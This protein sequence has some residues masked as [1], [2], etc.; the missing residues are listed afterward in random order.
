RGDGQRPRELLL[1]G[2]AQLLHHGE[3]RRAHVGEQTRLKLFDGGRVVEVVRAPAE[4]ASERG[5]RLVLREERGALLR[6]AVVELERLEPVF[7][8]REFLALRGR[9]LAQLLARLLVLPVY[10]LE[11]FARVLQ[12]AFELL[13]LRVEFVRVRVQARVVGE[14]WDALSARRVVVRQLARR[15]E[16][17]AVEHV[18]APEPRRFHEAALFDPGGEFREV[19]RRLQSGLARGG[20][21]YG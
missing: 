11:S 10:G 20:L 19:V 21:L 2:R 14:E 8:A 18:A 6:R 16:P 15:R 5:Q 12:L 1:I 3:R 17:D 9:L 7:D 4:V 13:A